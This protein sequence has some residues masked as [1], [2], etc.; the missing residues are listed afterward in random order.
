MTRSLRTFAA[1]TFFAA[2]VAVLAGPQTAQAGHDSPLYVAADRYR[3]AVSHFED[4]ARRVR[5]AK[6]EALLFRNDVLKRLADGSVTLAFRRWKRPA[7]RG[8]G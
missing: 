3:D 7:A 4:E 1:G 6:G 2:L 8:P 5:S